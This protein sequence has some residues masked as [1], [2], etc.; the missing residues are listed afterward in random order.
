MHKTVLALDQKIASEFHNS[1]KQTREYPHDYGE[2]RKLRIELQK[3]C[4]ITELEALNVLNCRNV[5]DYIAK[6]NSGNNLIYHAPVTT[7]VH[8][9]TYEGTQTPRLG[10][11]FVLPSDS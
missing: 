1:A 5:V 6:Y 4:G 8:K 10:S 7:K 3:L 11:S 2:M 9:N